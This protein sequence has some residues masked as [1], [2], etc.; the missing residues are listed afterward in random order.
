MVK[1]NVTNYIKKGDDLFCLSKTTSEE[2]ADSEPHRRPARP[3]LLFY[4]A[5]FQFVLLFHRLASL[6]YKVL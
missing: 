5:A 1:I 3:R 4:D 6:V 2:R